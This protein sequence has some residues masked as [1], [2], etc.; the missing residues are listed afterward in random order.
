VP[1]YTAMAGA[2]VSLRLRA[3]QVVKLVQGGSGDASGF[4]FDEIKDGYVAEKK[5]VADEVS[6][7][8]EETTNADF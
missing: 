2:G 7:Q 1:Y 3:V 6:V 4:G 8:E 5:E